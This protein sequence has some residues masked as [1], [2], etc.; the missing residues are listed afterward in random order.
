MKINRAFYLTDG[1][2]LARNL[3]GKVLVHNTAEGITKGRITEVEAYM[4]EEDKAS[5]SYKNRKTHRTE[6]QYGEGGF[7]YIYMIYGMHNCMNIVAN[8]EGVAQAV[9][10]RAL[11]P[12]Q[13]IELMEKRRNSKDIRALCSG[14]GRLCQAMGITKAQYGMDLCGKELYLEDAPALKDEEIEQS[15]RINIDYS[16]E[17]RDFLWR[18]SVKNCPYVS[19]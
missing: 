18:F 11:E 13:G 7:A 9:L 4:G 17:A 6:I 5:H 12:V 16:E 1:L 15:K 19:R 14:P 8:Q 10:I 3:L 2:V